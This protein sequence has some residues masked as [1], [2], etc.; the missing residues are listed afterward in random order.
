MQ[1]EFEDVGYAVAGG[2]ARIT[3][4][5]PDKLNAY[6]DQ[7]ADELL[8]AFVRAEGDGSV[9][10]AVLTGEGRAFGAGY[11]LS[12]LAP[13]AIP[14]LDQVLQEHFNP[15]VLQMRRSRLPIVT[16]VNGPCAGAAVG[17]A[18]A[19]DIVLAAAGRISTSRSSESRWCRMWG[20][21][22]SCR[23]WSGGCGQ[24]G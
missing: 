2:I 7:T 4:T 23:R 15:L 18:L 8:A 16:V 9:K 19:G 1:Q 10:V 14:A 11:D 21:R 22:F 6:R 24:R 5:R 17:V 12:T 13:D 3:V 20:T